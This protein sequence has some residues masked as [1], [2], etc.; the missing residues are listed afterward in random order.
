MTLETYRELFSYMAF[1]VFVT[2][3]DAKKII[4]KNVE[5][6]AF[7][8]EDNLKIKNLLKKQIKDSLLRL[9]IDIS[10]LEG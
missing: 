3:R 4:Y 5:R 7:N 2:T 10:C 6:N 8:Q 1:P 9:N